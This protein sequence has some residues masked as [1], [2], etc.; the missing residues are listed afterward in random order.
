MN[1]RVSECKC[2]AGRIDDEDRALLGPDGGL[3][4]AF[5]QFGAAGSEPT[6]VCAPTA[7][8]VDNATGASPDVCFLVGN[9]LAASGSESETQQAVEALMAA[10]DHSLSA[11]DE[12]EACLTDDDFAAMPGL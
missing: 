5:R 1:S 8:L 12:R 6:D 11:I 9:V 7:G 4:T 2:A 10:C 3:V